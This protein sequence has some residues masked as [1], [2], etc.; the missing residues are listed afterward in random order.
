MGAVGPD[1]QY[2]SNTYVINQEEVKLIEG[3]YKEGGHEY[4]LNDTHYEQHKRV[5]LDLSLL[6]DKILPKDLGNWLLP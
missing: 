4:A 5:H 2:D 3:I 1:N 6:R